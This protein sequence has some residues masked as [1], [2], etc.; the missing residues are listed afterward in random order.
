MTKENFDEIKT[1]CWKACNE[2]AG[3][4]IDISASTMKYNKFYKNIDEDTVWNDTISSFIG[5]VTSVKGR[6]E[7]VYSSLQD[8]L[9]DIWK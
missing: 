8:F 3:E 5:A 6:D 7:F 2:A 1:K 4:N 9:E